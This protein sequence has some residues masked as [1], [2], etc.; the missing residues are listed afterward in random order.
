MSAQTLVGWMESPTDEKPHKSAQKTRSNTTPWKKAHVDKNHLF[1]S[2]QLWFWKPQLTHCRSN[3]IFFQTQ[4]AFLNKWSANEITA[5][6]VHPIHLLK[7]F[8]WTKLILENNFT[9]IGTSWRLNTFFVQ[10]S[11]SLFDN[12]STKSALKA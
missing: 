11:K 3:L 12:Q 9:T 5:W 10:F 1:W 4:S 8:N 6:E 2:R 7:H